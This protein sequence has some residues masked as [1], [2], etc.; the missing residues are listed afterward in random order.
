MIMTAKGLNKS[1]TL[2]NSS[3]DLWYATYCLTKEVVLYYL[4]A[5]LCPDALG[6]V[7]E[8]VRYIPCFYMLS[9]W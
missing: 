6:P 5:S 2:L 9:S 8:K 7:N 1:F 3:S 4:S